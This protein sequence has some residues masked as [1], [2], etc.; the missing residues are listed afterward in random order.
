MLCYD[1]MTLDAFFRRYL[2]SQIYTIHTFWDLPFSMIHEPPS[3]Q[4][5]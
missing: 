1:I 4:A 5:G 2:Q 3:K